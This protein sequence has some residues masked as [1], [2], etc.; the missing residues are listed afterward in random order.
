MPTVIDPR[1]MVPRRHC[2]QLTNSK[3]EGK[4]MGPEVSDFFPRLTQEGNPAFLKQL[5]SRFKTQ[6]NLE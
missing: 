1:K 6:L 4:G 2:Q 3:G 5:I